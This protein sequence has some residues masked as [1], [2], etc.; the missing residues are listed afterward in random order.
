LKYYLGGLGSV[1]FQPHLSKRRWDAC[2]E[3]IAK[4]PVALEDLRNLAIGEEV[5]YD[6]SDDPAELGDCPTDSEV[7]DEPAAEARQQ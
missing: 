5:E 3:Q 1:R 4:N 6:D 7:D 2:V